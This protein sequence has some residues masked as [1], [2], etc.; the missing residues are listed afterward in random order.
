MQGT[1]LTTT[2]SFVTIIVMAE[3]EKR[4][5]YISFQNNKR[6]HSSTE[7]LK[8]P[9]NNDKLI[10]TK[11][12]DI[13]L[14]EL[15]QLNTESDNKLVDVVIV[16]DDSKGVISEEPRKRSAVSFADDVV[17][18]CDDVGV[19]GVG[20][21]PRPTRVHFSEGGDPLRKSSKNSSIDVY[22]KTCLEILEQQGK[23][24]QD[25]EFGS[26]FISAAIRPKD[27]KI[28]GVSHNP[29]GVKTIQH[30]PYLPQ[31]TLGP[32]TT[33][34]PQHH[35]LSYMQ[36]DSSSS[37]GGITSPTKF[38]EYHPSALLS[39][40]CE[41]QIKQQQRRSSSCPALAIEAAASIAAGSAV[42]PVSS[43]NQQ[44]IQMN[45]ES[46]VMAFYPLKDI[47]VNN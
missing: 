3:Q 20:V 29:T 40:D 25:T 21:N 13:T 15:N 37:G 38:R 1:E 19:R 39:I 16:D 33:I 28:G 5:S 18:G 36:C 12:S 34:K 44:T 14:T 4:N 31:A 8:Q 30:G 23:G 35:R 11:A 42:Q 17:G 2:Y 26:G 43:S 45:P 41:Q 46:Q 7:N 22:E 9:H 10:D 6:K 32:Q 47:F 27:L 24:I